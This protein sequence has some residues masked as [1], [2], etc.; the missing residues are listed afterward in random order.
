M[1]RKVSKICI[2]YK[3][4]RDPLEEKGGG[5]GGGGGG[6]KSAVRHDIRNC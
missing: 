3:L 4:A 1:I 2:N 6:E 5:R